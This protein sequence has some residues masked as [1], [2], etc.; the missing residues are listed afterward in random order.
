[1]KIEELEDILSKYKISKPS[2]KSEEVE[3]KSLP[4]MLTTFREL[5][6]DGIPPNQEEFIRVFKEKY[7]DL[8]CKGIGSR[9]KRSYLSY[10][11]EYHLGFLLR[12]HFSKV[13]YDEKIDLFGIDYIIYYKKCK[14]NIHAF[15]NTEN[16]RYWRGIKN[17]RHKFRGH[18][19]DMPIDLDS[20]KRVG[21]IILYTDNHIAE[22]KKQMEKIINDKKSGV[23]NE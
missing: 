2:V 9:L 6:K 15:V 8:K 20:G 10:V 21:R 14:F 16:S 12:R 11:R 19:I 13:I 5:I 4:F 7:P 23:L 3:N 1:M 17:G 18:H 22:L